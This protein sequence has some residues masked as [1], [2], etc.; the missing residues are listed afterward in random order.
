[1]SQYLW[2][3]KFPYSSQTIPRFKIFKLNC[4][5]KKK[6]GLNGENSGKYYLYTISPSIVC[7]C[8]NGEFNWNSNELSARQCRVEN[9]KFVYILLFCRLLGFLLWKF[10]ATKASKR[11]TFFLQQMD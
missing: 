11:A 8:L 10:M 3:S 1:M 5:K 4:Q 2:K 9:M 6:L 7:L